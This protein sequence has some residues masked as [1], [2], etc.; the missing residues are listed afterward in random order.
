MKNKVALTLLPSNRVLDVPTGKKLSDVIRDANMPL[1]FSCGGR[2]VCIAC[3]V[4]TQGE[5]SPM[6]QRERDLLDS[7]ESAPAGWRVRL[8]CLARVQNDGAVRTT[9]W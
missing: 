2:G 3:V 1:G 5:F 7:V 9:Y 4:Y 6:T 8:A